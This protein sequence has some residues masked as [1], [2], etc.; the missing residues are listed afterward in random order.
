[1]LGMPTFTCS[2]NTK[3]VSKVKKELWGPDHESFLEY[4]LKLG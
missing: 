3:G 1:M 2:K 4:A